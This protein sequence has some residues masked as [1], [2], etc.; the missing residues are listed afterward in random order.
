MIDYDRLG[1]NLS[2]DLSKKVVDHRNRFYH[3][4]I[5]RYLEGLANLF[6]YN[7]K[8]FD[9][10]TLEIALREGY[11]VAV[12]VNKFNQLQVLGYIN[13]NQFAYNRPDLLLKPRRYTG[14]DINFVIP[15]ELL[16]ERARSKNFLEIWQW[17]NGQTGDFVVFWNKQIN[18][19]NDFEIIEHYASEL[20]EIVA[21]RFSLIMQ[22][23]VQTILTGDVG[24]ETLNQMISAIYNGNPFVKLARTFDVDDHLIQ[25]NNADLANDLA[26]LKTEYQN[27]IAELNSLFGINVLSVEKESGVSA[28]ESNGNLGFVNM[29]ANIW[30][31]SRQKALN[32]LNERFHKNY[33]VSIDNTGVAMLGG[34]TGNEND[35]DPTRPNNSSSKH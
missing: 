12:G 19:T 1:E 24:D 15:D 28:S 29:N 20:A 21:S 2:T 34:E 35:N 6:Y 33:S 4:F 23:K 25:I 27:K 22:A 17:D 14:S 8:P 5:N 16:P 32:L 30:L 10:A 13:N 11:G 9:K 31:E 18:L 3:F 7:I 26:E